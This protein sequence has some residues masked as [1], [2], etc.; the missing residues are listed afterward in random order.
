MVGALAWNTQILTSG[1]RDRSIYHRDVRAPDPWLKE[2]VGHKQEVA[3]SSKKLKK[4]PS[5]AEYQKTP[6]TSHGLMVP[7]LPAAVEATH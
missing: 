7:S 3:S 6:E 4:D 2:L 5:L 1:S